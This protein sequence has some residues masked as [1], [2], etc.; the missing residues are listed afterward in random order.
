MKSGEMKVLIADDDFIQRRL[1]QARLASLG[2]E[3]TV[4]CSGT[5]A[6]QIL[7]GEAPPALAVLDWMM[8]GIDGVTLCR[9]IRQRGAEPYTYI[10]LLTSKTR[11]EDLLE[12]LDAG[13][14][15]YLTKPVDQEELAVRLRTGRRILTLQEQLI[16]ARE[17]LRDLAAH[18]PLTGLWNHSAILQALT[19][20][21]ARAEREAG[22]V[23]IIMAD[24]DH[25]KQVNDTHGHGVGDLV[26]KETARRLRDAVRVY[27]LVGR[28]GGEEFLIVLPGC[29][30]AD[31]LV[32]GER[33]RARISDTPI[34]TPS[35]PLPVTVSVGATA[36]KPESRTGVETL[37]QT[38]DNA[39]YRAKRGGRNR[40]EYGASP[41]IAPARA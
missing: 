39:L 33:I 21:V 2:Y 34:E 15:D 11:K 9:R 10:I 12:G 28:V 19:A 14:D 24:L 4:A 6:W 8:P 18:D 7:Q 41:D 22:A 30:R 32:L 27:D 36:W 31:V 29:N 38:A 40:V 23:G 16:A 25:F 37:V 5:E 3:T 20:E 1:L 17:A 13:A 35:G 26:L